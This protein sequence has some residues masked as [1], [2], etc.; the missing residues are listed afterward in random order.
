M[1]NRSITK[2]QYDHLGNRGDMP[3]PGQRWLVEERDACGV[4]FIASTAGTA[5]HKL[6][7]QALIALGCLEHRGACS[8][9]QDS[10]D[11]AGLM[12]AIPWKLFEPWFAEQGITMPPTEQLGVG[13]VFLPRDGTLVRKARE[14]VENV[15]KQDN[16]T[17]LGWRKVPVQESVVGSQARENLPQIE[18]VF[19][20]SMGERGDDLERTL[21]RFRRQIGKALETEGRLKWSDDFYICSFSNRTIV[22]KG[23]VRSVVLGEFYTDLKN[24]DYQSTFAVYHRRFSTNTMPKWPLAQPM[25]LL[26]HNGEINTLLGNINWM[27]AREADLSHPLWG[28]PTQESEI[29]TQEAALEMPAEAPHTEL[30][31]LKP[32]VNPDNSDS[33]TLDNVL[34]LLVRSGR[35]PVEA[36]MIMVPEAYQNQPDLENYPEIIDFYEYYSGIQEA[37]D[38]PALLVFSDGKT[39]GA[40]LDRNGLRP[41]RYSITR[42][43]YV[44]VSSEA[45]VVDLPEAEIIEK[46]RLGPGQMI[47]VDLENHEILKN[48]EIKQRVAKALPYGEWLAQHRQVLQPQSFESTPQLQERE[49]LRQQ[50]AFGYTAEDIEMILQPM[51]AQGKEATFCMGDD[52]PLAVLSNK[53]RL[54]Y[55]YFKQRFAQ[56]TNPPIDPLRESLV[57]SLSIEL[58]ERGNLLEAKPE[59]ARLLKLKS[60]VLNEAELEVV[61]TSEFKTTQLSTLFEIATGPGGLEVAVHR[62]RD[63]AAEAVKAGS[64]ILVL[65]DKIDPSTSFDFAQDKSLRVNA[66]ASLS[67]NGGARESHSYIPPLL[68]VGAVHHHLIR[69]GLRM[70]ASIVVETAQC[71]STHHFACLIGYGASAICPYLAWESV[72]SWWSD[73]K[74]Q[75]LMERGRLESITIEEAQKNYRK[76]VEAGLLKILSKMGI[77]LLSSY[78]GA[79]IFE[80]IGIGSDL[81]KLAFAGTTS[82]LGGLSV[83][84]LAQE[85]ISFH[86]RAFPELSG[87]KLENF[88]FIQYRPG[89]EY[90]MNSPEMAKALHKAVSSAERSR[91]INPSA[92]FDILRHRSGQVAQDKSLRVQS[93]SNGKQTTASE[94]E[95]YDHYEVYKKYLEERPVTALRD[96]LDFK[97]D[98]TPIPVE[99]VEPVADIVQRFCTGA[100]SLGSLSR[101]AHETLAIAMNRIGGKSNSGEG[102]EDPV[103][104]KILDDV[105]ESGNSPTLPHLKGLRNGDTASSATKQVASGRFGV[106]PEYLMSGKQLEI[107]I[108]QGAKPGEGGQLPGKKVS[109]YIA[110]LRRSKPGVPLISPPPHHDIYSIEDLAQLIFDL[111]Q[112]N[113]QAHVSVKLVAE[114]G[115]GTVAAGVAKANADVIQISG[116]DGG[117][118]ASPLSSIKHAGVPWELG[119]TEV[120]RVLMENQLRDRVLLR[121]DGGF[122]TGW[123][124]V[125]AALMGAEEYGFGSVSMIAEGCIMARICHTNNC[126]VGVATQQEHLRKRF[127]GMPENV[128]N[129]FYFVA[130]EVRSLLARLGYRKLEE[131]IGRADLLKARENVTLT[132]TSTLTVKCLTDLPDTRS[133][134]SW[135]QH[136][137]VHS[138]GPV[139]DDRLLADE[140]IQSCLCNQGS[141][142][143]TLNVVNTDRT[144]GARLAGAIAKQYGNTGFEGQ[145]TLNFK[146]AAGQS[147]GA[148]NLP[149]MTLILTGEANDYVGKGMHGGEIII[150]PPADATYDPAEN[151]IVGNTC[152]YGATGGT[153]FANGGA[154]ERFAVRNSK[155]QAVIEGAGDHCCEYMTGGVVVV[156][157]HVGRNVGAGM[158]GGL[159]YFLD[160]D[161]S[162]PAKVNP[163]I[164]KMQRVTTSAGEQQ[165]KELIQAHADRTGS[166]KAKLILANWSDYLPKFWQ[167]VPPSEEDT[168]EANPEAVKERQLSS[169]Q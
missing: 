162:F 41:A 70:K 92:S 8:A 37:W 47:A 51:V 64:K 2:N 55:D 114:I 106:T 110:M 104:F 65:S 157:G 116:H 137:E 4:G 10:G 5:S 16:L 83:A 139:L 34:E 127:T 150:K 50:T 131:V 97:S 73:S 146:G 129:F 93:T 3:Y 151:V 1:E 87:K 130:E 29:R 6:I 89:G 159:A 80:A 43:G 86:Q 101:E 48:W 132:K 118:G 79:Q 63:Q 25:R 30:E 148:F 134:R 124:V 20:S 36:L 107:K 166:A 119:V 144:V 53:P 126:P 147:F 142:T 49:L 42:D 123:D 105:D 24:P 169:V 76:A 15:L 125:M 165:L 145:I 21:F 33:A 167:V 135:L 26:G 164:V 32:I 69:Q 46:G 113:P 78:Q 108:A 12:T 138:N 140:G 91:S 100:M 77:S 128:V 40:T 59:Y 143:K 27:M 158:T 141:V 9:D 102:G 18:Q 161:G 155:G 38:G 22:Y 109:P 168:P 149:G 163:E 75:K 61:K 152:L 115:I 81:L 122:K 153:L 19:V 133:E 88:G 71:W 39:V 35:S 82:R 156:L 103:R 160:E 72:R 62:L 68:A 52:I 95:A 67:I 117:T 58:G 31:D 17:V 154:G 11:G 112:I 57:M 7:E 23:M 94:Q 28:S 44:V 45:G 121:A 56:V 120:H 84:E 60:P 90:H 136:E 54:L 111:H 99:E 96:L 66:S 98:R 74:T 85:V 13:M 14:T